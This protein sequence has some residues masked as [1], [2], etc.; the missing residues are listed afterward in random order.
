MERGKEHV[1]DIL[2]WLSQS[3]PEDL[4]LA[5]VVNGKAKTID[6]QKG[7]DLLQLNGLRQNDINVNV[8][9]IFSLAKQF[10]DFTGSLAHSVITYDDY[11]VIIM[12]IAV[13]MILY[14]ICATGAASAIVDGLTSKKEDVP[15]REESNKWVVTGYNTDFVSSDWTGR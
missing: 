11:E 2:E 1:Q 5:G 3:F 14:V 8:S 7:S 12:D 13:D 6:Y 15:D 4:I 9:L 10:E